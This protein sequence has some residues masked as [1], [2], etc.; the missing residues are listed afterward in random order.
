MYQR[1]GHGTFTRDLASYDDCRMVLQSLGV[2]LADV[3]AD[4][5]RSLHARMRAAHEERAA[6]GNR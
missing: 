6:A 4:E 2:S 1:T 5:L 3:T